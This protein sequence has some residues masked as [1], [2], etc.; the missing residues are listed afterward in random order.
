ME[1]LWSMWNKGETFKIPNTCYTLKGFSIAALR[2]NFY[3][4]ELKVMLDGGLSA[5]V[6]PDNILVTHC[7][8]DHV[9][10][11]PYHLYSAIDKKIT[12]FAPAE[13][14]QRI[15]RYIQAAFAMTGN[16]DE[17][18]EEFNKNLNSWYEMIPAYKGRTEII[19]SGNRTMGLEIIPCDHGVPSIGFGLI[20][21]RLKLKAEY[22]QLPGKELGNLKKSGVEINYEVEMPFFLYLG[23][24]SEKVLLD[25]NILK[26]RT[27][28]IECTFLLEEESEQATM[29]K[30]MHW[31]HLYP[32]IQ[33]HS[34]IFFVIYHFSQRYKAE[35]IKA[36][37]E[38]FLKEMSNFHPWISS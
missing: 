3:I 26:Y 11:L 13:N 27:I 20:E 35:E 2:T 22:A 24:T 33:A 25:E 32:F 30:H 23:D 28:M 6:S 9:A 36:F 34:E 15:N 31:K 1:T 7:H 18:D 10:N 5:N 14:Y 4:P 19:V 38:P 29:T 17:N 8:S 12:I 37:F 21:K 16:T